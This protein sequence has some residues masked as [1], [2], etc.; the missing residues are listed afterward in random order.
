MAKRNDRWD[1]MLRILRSIDAKL[2]RMNEQLDKLPVRKKRKGEVDV[3]SEKIVVKGVPPTEGAKDDDD[4]DTLTIYT[5]VPR[6][7]RDD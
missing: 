6:A 1:D 3:V 4:P 7:G 2:G 5:G